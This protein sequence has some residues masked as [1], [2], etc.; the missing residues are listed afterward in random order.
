MERPGMLRPTELI[1]NNAVPA[2]ADDAR[3]AQNGGTMK[4]L[5]EHARSVVLA[6]LLLTIAGAASAQNIYKCS[7]GGQAEYTDR[8]CV[9]QP[10]QLIH[11]AD[12]TEVIDQYLDLGQD[13]AA[14]GY[15]DSHN[16]LPLYKERLDVRQ[17]R[18]NAKVQKQADDDAAQKV[19]D[20]AASQQAIVD[21]AANRGRL[22]GE[23]DALR[24]QNA[25]YRDKLSQPV[26]NDAGA[27]FNAGPGYGYGYGYPAYGGGSVPGNGHGGG[28]GPGN[29]PGKPPGDG[30]NGPGHGHDTPPKPPPTA[31]YHPCIQIAGG[32]VKC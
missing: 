15:A 11:Q 2:R 19:S 23:N 32:T 27:Y 31:V 9:G 18:L 6:I 1:L 24:Q 3:M 16:L 14:K 13:D 21:A 20:A 25:D 8:P 26:T 12:D 17:R 22:Q 30:G 28:H 7:K 4:T 29:D 5:S 10:G